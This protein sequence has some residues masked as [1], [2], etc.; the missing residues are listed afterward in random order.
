RRTALVAYD[1]PGACRDA[2]DAGERETEL[3]R[4]QAKTPLG[5]FRSSKAQLVVVAA[6][7]KTSQRKRALA[8]GDALVDRPAPWNPGHLHRGADARG[9]Q[10]MTEIADQAIGNIDRRS[11]DSSQPLAERHPRRRAQERG[12]AARQLIGGERYAA[13]MVREGERRVAEPARHV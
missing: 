1:Q 5:A 9:P 4:E 12:V 8:H 7:E 2:A 6:R 10:Q 3:L 13:P 11:G